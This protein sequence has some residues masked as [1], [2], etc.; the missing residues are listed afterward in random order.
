MYVCVWVCVCI[1]ICISLY[2]V[3]FFKNMF[4]KVACDLLVMSSL[5]GPLFCVW[6]LGLFLVFVLINRALGGLP[7]WRSGGTALAASVWFP[8]RQPEFPV[9]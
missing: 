3:V 8:G 6:D 9:L 7:G 2:P 5:L 1:S 4:L